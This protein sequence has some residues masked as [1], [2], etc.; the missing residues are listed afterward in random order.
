MINRS[1]HASI[2]I[3]GILLSG[4]LAAPA[5]AQNFGLMPRGAC[6]K[7]S[8]A[9]VSHPPQAQVQQRPAYDVAYSA[10][11]PAPAPERKRPRRRG[12][13]SPF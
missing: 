3:S 8:S 9:A 2:L 10:A 13:P 6:P 11:A 7:I 12:F 1:F 4:V 5:S